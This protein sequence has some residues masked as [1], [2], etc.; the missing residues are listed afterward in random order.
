M[1]G[2][3]YNHRGHGGFTQ[4][5][6]DLSD[7]LAFFVPFVV[8]FLKMNRQ[9]RFGTGSPAFCPSFAPTR[10]PAQAKAFPP[11]GFKMYSLNHDSQD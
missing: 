6:T 4:R 2:I 8:F 1:V 10:R 3:Y 5:I 7:V 11:I 9:W